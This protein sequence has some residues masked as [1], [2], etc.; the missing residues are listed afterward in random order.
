M[1][2]DVEPHPGPSARERAVGRDIFRTVDIRAADV[3]A[4]TALRYEEAFAD[5]EV[6]LS[7][8]SRDPIAILRHEGARAL[9]TAAAEYLYAQYREMKLSSSSAGTFCSAVRRFLHLAE[10]AGFELH[11]DIKSAMRPLWRVQ[12]SWETLVP[13]EFRSPVSVQGAL[14]LTVAAITRGWYKTAVLILISF[15]CLLRPDEARSL[16]YCDVNFIEPELQ[17]RYKD[18]Y[19]ILRVTKPKTRRIHS[20]AT[21]QH[22]VIQDRALAVF[23]KRAWSKIPDHRQG[24]LIWTNT[25]SIH[26]YRFRQLAKDISSHAGWTLAG[27]RGGGATDFY[28]RTMD[29]VSLRR[30]GRWAQLAT[31]DRYVQEAAACLQDDNVSPAD[32][33]KISELARIGAKLLEE[34]EFPAPLCQ[35]L[36]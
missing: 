30:R 8:R 17:T 5:F 21:V 18:V 7:W 14:A 22:V 3:N 32:R 15:H 27:L 9:V 26:G 23:L 29:V 19:A 28:L 13:P 31:V 4:T 16:R 33:A 24:E 12:K 6:F 34:Y 36:L 2:G 35:A 20:A 10:S 11:C 25:A 1:C